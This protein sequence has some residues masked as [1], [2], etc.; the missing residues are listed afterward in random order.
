MGQTGYRQ[1]IIE[2]R[3]TLLS[4]WERSLHLPH[5]HPHQEEKGSAYRRRGES[6]T[7]EEERRSRDGTLRRRYLPK[8]LSGRGIEGLQGGHGGADLHQGGVDIYPI[9]GSLSPSG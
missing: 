4:P 7:K 9:H 3:G 6:H 2:K 1:K 8:H 5:L